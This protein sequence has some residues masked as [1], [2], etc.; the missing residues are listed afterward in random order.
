MTYYITA[1][2]KGNK[3]QMPV[4]EKHLYITD[5]PVK[6]YA[7]VDGWYL[8]TG[9]LL[10]LAKYDTT[11]IDAN[12]NTQGY[13]TRTTSVN[14]TAINL[15][16]VNVT[17]D[18]IV[19]VYQPYTLTLPKGTGTNERIGDKIFIKSVKLM[20]NINFNYYQFI[21]YISQDQK[22]DN[23]IETDI[24]GQQV[25]NTVT[26]YVNNRNQTNAFFKLRF[27]LVRFDELD[28]GYISTL[29][30]EIAKWFNSTF[31]PSLYAPPSQTNDIAIPFVSN[32]AKML[33]E[34]TA[35]TG[36][37]KIIKD[38]MLTIGNKDPQK[39]I[40]IDLEPKMNI[41]F[42]PDDS[43]SR[44]GYV[45]NSEWTN[46]IGFFILPSYYQEDMDLVSYSHI[47]DGALNNFITI[48]KNIKMTYYDL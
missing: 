6:I 39:H 43:T 41:T 11:T 10:N 38:I 13:S 35:Y 29:N 18:K 19:R 8:R 45:S 17:G 3:L 4:E 31:V 48:D 34:S 27:M 21:Q 5:R 28:Q 42:N 26:T 1:H 24:S 15:N 7:S 46:V 12:I 36:K 33:R 16:G 30:D 23:T 20:F 37:F 9:L 2:K 40:E 22:D 44:A 32:Q 47:N 25:Q 14:P